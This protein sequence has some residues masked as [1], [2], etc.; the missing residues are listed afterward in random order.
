MEGKAGSAQTPMLEALDEAKLNWRFHAMGIAIMFGSVLEF[1]DFYLIAFVVSELDDEWNLTFGQVTAMLLNAGL[2]TIFGALLWGRIGDRTG[3]RK[4][5]IAGVVIFSLGTGALALAPEGGWW[6]IALV[7]FVVGIGVGGVAAVAVPML[8]EMTPTRLRTKLAGFMLTALIPIGVLVAG[9][10]A[11]VA[12]D[13]LGW[14]TLF[15]IGVFPIVLAFWTAFFVPESPRWLIDQGRLEEA[16]GVISWMTM[17]PE[18]ELS[19]ELPAAERKREHERHGDYKELARYK[20]SFWT[21]TLAWFGSACAAGGIVL[22][23]PL[24]VEAV[25]DVS[26]SKAAALFSFITLGSFFGR[27]T[28]AFLPLKIGRRAC[29]ALMGVGGA[30][31]LVCTALFYD[32]HLGAV[33]MFLLLL[34]LANFFIDGGLANLV[35]YSPEIFPTHLRAHGMGLA[36]AVNGV[37]RVIGPLAIGLIAGASTEVDPESVVDSVTPG[38]LVLAGCAAIS[39]IP[40][41]TFAREPHGS[42]LE[43]LAAELDGEVDETRAPAGA[44]PS[45][46]PAS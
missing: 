21:V 37:G 33:S 12:L 31:L 1:F 39:A 16:R 30:G 27:V 13:P 2:G 3:R 11:A 46:R 42:S 24:F 25:E 19:T 7:R 43:S 20:H 22:W 14:R 29:G 17:T 28:F 8:L 26:E 6:Y 38:F 36:Q 45:P 23:G 9:V 32:Q 5:L 10:L 4:P 44:A 41:F 15:A 35:P 18:E 34:V 40:F